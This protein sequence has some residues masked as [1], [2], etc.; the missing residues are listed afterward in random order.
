MTTVFKIR[1][2]AGLF[3]TGGDTPSWSKKGKAWSS[4]GALSNH[5]TLVSDRWASAG[6]PHGWPRKEPAAMPPHPYEGCEVIT[7]VLQ[8]TA[9]VPITP[10]LVARADR[11]I[12]HDTTGYYA[13]E[14]SHANRAKLLRAW[15]ERA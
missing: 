5:I 15:K 2:R 3:S 8:P 9:T 10:E 7:L 14:S 1:N 13:E 6:L 11:L 4:K 12:E